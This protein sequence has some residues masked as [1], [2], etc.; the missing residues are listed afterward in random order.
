MQNL[1]ITV[2]TAADVF[3]ALLLI[4]LV[5]VQQ[6]KEGAFGSSPFG[7]VGESVF[8]AQVTGHMARLTVIFSALFLS[9]TLILA[10][11]IGHRAEPASIIER[12]I[13]IQGSKTQNEKPETKEAVSEK[14]D[15][16]LNA[17]P[18][19]ENEK[20]SPAKNPGKEPLTANAPDKDSSGTGKKEDSP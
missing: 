20:A 19:P 17:N 8:G 15:K 2:L 3:V 13:A 7:G 5:L 4:A 16:N 18:A 9:I 10:I 14:A 1:I 12:E 11:I 6:S